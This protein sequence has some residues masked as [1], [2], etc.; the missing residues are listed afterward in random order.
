M[1]F[2]LLISYSFLVK[3]HCGACLG[4]QVNMGSSHYLSQYWPRSMSPYGITRPQ[5]VNSLAPGRCGSNIK[6]I[7]FKLV[8]QNSNLPTCCEI[9]LRRMPK[10]LT[11]DWTTLVQVMVWCRQATSHYLRQCWPRSMSL[12]DVTRP[13]KVQY[14]QHK[15]QRLPWQNGLDIHQGPA[16]KW[17]VSFGMKQNMR[18]KTKGENSFWEA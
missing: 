6:S 15:F 8:K 14:T 17:R 10:N 13:L 3:L 1:W 7:I 2:L 9:T 18:R 11:N 5:W 16:W 4:S 12:Y